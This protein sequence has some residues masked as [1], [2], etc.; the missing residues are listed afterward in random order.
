MAK[1]PVPSKKQA[2]SSTGSRHAKYGFELKKRIIQSTMLEKR[3]VCGAAKRRHYACATCG[4]YRGRTV[5]DK[6]A[7]MTAPIKEIKA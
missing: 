7:K 3:S 1:K 2:P 5:I 4:Q 6:S